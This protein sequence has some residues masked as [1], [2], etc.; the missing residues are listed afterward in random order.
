MTA[1]QQSGRATARSVRRPRSDRAAYLYLLP[2]FVVLTL[3]LFVPLGH[4]AWIS[5]FDWDGLSVGTWTGFDNYVQIVTDPSLRMAFVRS[6]VLILFFAVVPISLALLLTMLMSRANRLRGLGFFRVVIFLPQVVSSVVVGAIW[7]AIYAP[8]G[9]LNQFLSLIGLEAVTK[10]WLG[11]F[12]W[13][14]P[15]V[16][17]IGT[18]VT[19]GL[20]LVLFL[21]GISQIDPAL[22]EAARIDGAGMLREFFAVTLPGLRAQL[23]VALTLTTVAALR[24]FDLIYVA[25]RGGPGEATSVPAFQ[26]YHLA[27]DLKQVGAAAAM[28]VALTTLIFGLTYLIG[29]IDRQERQS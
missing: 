14:L 10:P 27:F 28:G 2:A 5:L 12:T 9:V 15:A 17:L 22:Y 24:S 6:L 1:G 23:A 3:F 8:N 7:V 18:W 25:T 16:G 4:G 26:V 20:C 19:I 11:D 13:A 21:A 29:R